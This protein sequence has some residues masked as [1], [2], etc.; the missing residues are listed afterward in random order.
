MN[1][2][3]G[4][5]AELDQSDIDHDAIAHS[6]IAYMEGYLVSA[7]CSRQ[8]AIKVRQIA[9]DRKI[10]TAL[11]L[12]DPNMVLFF[13]EGLNEMIGDGVD[14]LFANEDE[15]CELAQTRDINETIAKLKQC[16]STFAITR[17]KQ[18]AVVFDGKELLEIAP[19]PV[20]AIDTL[21]AGDMFAGSFMYA[22]SQGMNYQQA[23][24]LASMASAQIV[25]KFGPRLQAN[26][27]QEL[28]HRFNSGI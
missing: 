5:S 11:T 8:A 26:E 25:T 24:K 2:F 7:D 15:A 14:L 4:A 17:G 3:L 21:G 16:A 13:R 20:E 1:T 19:H 22:L 9:E 10:K 18:G 12:S 28:L 23:G 6:Q 27:T